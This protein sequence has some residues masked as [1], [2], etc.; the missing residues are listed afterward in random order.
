MT[1]ASICD[2][3]IGGF[4][5]YRKLY[6]GVILVS[7]EDIGSLLDFSK[8]WDTIVEVREI[9]PLEEDLKVLSIDKD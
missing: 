1:R 5:T 4:D 7:D 8:G 9:I 2:Y 6:R 3:F